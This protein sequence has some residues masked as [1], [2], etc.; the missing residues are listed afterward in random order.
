MVVA[1]KGKC[2]FYPYPTLPT[3]R[4]A[5]KARCFCRSIP[6]LFL[7]SFLDIIELVFVLN[8]QEIYTAGC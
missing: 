4:M 1:T 2:F 8:M 6:S 5:V 3:F 7:N